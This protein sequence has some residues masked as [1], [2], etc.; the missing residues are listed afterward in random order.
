MTFLAL[1]D[2]NSD[3]P[4]GKFLPCIEK[5]TCN[6]SSCYHWCLW[7]WCCCFI[8]SWQTLAKCAI[9]CVGIIATT[10]L[11]IKVTFSFVQAIIT[12]SISNEIQ[13]L[14]TNRIEFFK[15]TFTFCTILKD[16]TRSTAV[17]SIKITCII[18]IFIFTITISNPISITTMCV[19]N[20]IR[21]S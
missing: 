12:K 21:I 17:S 5:G 3:N 8:I 13:L 9:I 10:I 7:S 16:D 15:E 14:A 11:T 18:V 20:K 2:D 4:Q 1:F 19:W 6:C